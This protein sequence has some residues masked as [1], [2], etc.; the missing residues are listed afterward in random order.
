MLFSL[1]LIDPFTR[2][3]R[4]VRLT[5]SRLIAG[6]FNFEGGLRET[7]AR[8]LSDGRI[9]ANLCVSQSGK[10]LPLEELDLPSIYVRGE[11]VQ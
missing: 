2:E 7:A 1:A 9:I 3:L 6:F 11:H 8:K 10:V 4:R 5:W